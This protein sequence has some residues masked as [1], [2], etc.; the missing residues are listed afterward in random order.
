MTDLFIYFV[1][2]HKYIIYEE[3]P[4]RFMDIDINRI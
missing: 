2:V 1:Y 4:D 3:E